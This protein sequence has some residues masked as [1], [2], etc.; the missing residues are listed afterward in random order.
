M[1]RQT[2]SV[3]L[4][5]CYTEGFALAYAHCSSYFLGITTRLR[6]SILLTIPVAFIYIVSLFSCWR[7]SLSLTILFTLRVKFIQF[8]SG[9]FLLGARRGNYFQEKRLQKLPF[10]IYDTLFASKQELLLKSPSVIHRQHNQQ[11]TD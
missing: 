4:C 5:Q 3:E 9:N 6:S 1:Y 11:Q 2:K 10:I 7:I 8:F